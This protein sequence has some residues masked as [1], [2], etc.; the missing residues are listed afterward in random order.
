MNDIKL[1]AERRKIE[2]VILPTAEAIKASEKKTD[3]NQRRSPRHVLSLKRL[4]AT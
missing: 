1:E 4:H 3:S 2:L